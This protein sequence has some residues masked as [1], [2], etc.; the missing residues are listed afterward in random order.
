MFRNRKALLFGVLLFY[1]YFRG[2][3]SHGLIDP[4]EGINASISLHMSAGSSS[5][6]PRIGEIFAAGRTLGTWWLE[7]LALKLFGWSEFAVRFFPALSGLIM[8]LMSALAS[9]ES[10]SL[11]TRS[12]W[13]SASICAGMTICFTVSQLASPHAIFAALMSVTMAGIIHSHEKKHWLFISHLASTLSFIAYGFEGL[14][15]TWLSVIAYSVLTDDTDMLLDFF[16]WPPGMIFTVTVSGLYFVLLIIV[17]TDIIQFMHCRVHT[18]NFG[19]IMGMCIFAFVSFMPFHGFILR[20]IYEII[21]KEYPASKSP[22]IFMLVWAIVFGVSAVLTGDMLMLSCTAVPLSAILGKKLDFW[23]DQKKLYP[24]IISVMLNIV[25]LVP[26]VFMLLPFMMSA[27]PVIRISMLSLIPW[28][29]TTGLFLFASWYYTKT[30]QIRKWVRNVPGAA[31]LCL[32][33]LAGVF[34]LTANSYSIRDIGLMLR[35][36]VQGRDMVIQY[37]VNYP[38]VYFYSLRNSRIIDAELMSG[39]AEKKFITDDEEL[40]RLWNGEDRVFMIIPAERRVNNSLPKNIYSILEI[41]G[42]LLITNQK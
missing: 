13:L 33:P 30:R 36:I 4:L 5:F 35:E 15:L 10:K 25:L 18:Y 37:S 22:E 17:N 7:A 34:S 41:N 19:G 8:I 27:L 16:T 12:S 24:V 9:H 42:M 21:P 11:S 26:V 23:L 14:M 31:L 39:V 2:I 38:S 28:G 3:G 1:L 40:N 29:I 6:I 20:A 32:M